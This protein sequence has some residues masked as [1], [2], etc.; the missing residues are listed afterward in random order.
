MPLEK[1]KREILQSRDDRQQE[2][3]RLVQGGKP[4]VSLSANIPGDDKKPAGFND[5]FAHVCGL[6]KES[7][8]LVYTCDDALGPFALFLSETPQTE[9]KR[10][11]VTIENAHAWGRLIDID[12][13]DDAGL[14]ISRASLGFEERGCLICSDTA[15]SCIKAGRHSMKDLMRAAN[16][17]IDRYH[18]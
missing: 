16:D 3:D 8:E 6:V 9:L 17:I 5:I 12:V 11:M 15:K 2:I 10:A 7:A 13:Y 18:C 14:P 4:L 1:L